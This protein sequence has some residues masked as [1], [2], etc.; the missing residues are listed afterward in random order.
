MS[1]EL[2]GLAGGTDGRAAPADHQELI[3]AANTHCLEARSDF[4]DYKVIR[5]ICVIRGRKTGYFDTGSNCK[6]KE[7]Y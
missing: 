4:S 2:R 5:E 1:Q 6:Y 3:S 7:G